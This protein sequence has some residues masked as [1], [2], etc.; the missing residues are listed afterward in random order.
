MSQIWAQMVVEGATNWLLN[1]AAVLSAIGILAVDAAFRSRMPAAWSIV[2]WLTALGLIATVIVGVVQVG[3]DLGL[4]L[5]FAGL[6]VLVP[7]WSIWLGVSLRAE[8][9]VAPDPGSSRVCLAPSAA[10]VILSTRAP[11]AQWIERWVPDPKVAGSS[12]VGRA[13]AMSLAT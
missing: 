9:T 6:G 12:P 3:E 1:G 8:P 13:N 4:Y 10:P 11:V 5:L 7:L 2:S